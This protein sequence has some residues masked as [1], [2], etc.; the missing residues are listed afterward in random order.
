MKGGAPG[1]LAWVV[2]WALSSVALPSPVRSQSVVRAEVGASS[3]SEAYGARAEWY[4][5]RFDGWIGVLGFD[6][7][8]VG[9]QLHT[10]WRGLDAAV[11]DLWLSN[12]LPTDRFG[13]G[14][15]ALGRGLAVADSSGAFGWTV[16]G[17]WTAR[18]R[19]L[20]PGIVTA[21]GKKPMGLAELRWAPRPELEVG[22]RRTVTPEGES[23]L[24]FGSWSG[25]SVRMD[26]AVGSLQGEAYLSVAATLVTRSVEADVSWTHAPRA[27]RRVA[28]P[29]LSLPEL[30]GLNARVAWRPSEKWRVAAGRV[31]RRPSPFLPDTTPVR[32]IYDVSAGFPAGRGVSGNASFH[33]S[34]GSSGE[35]ASYGGHAGLSARPWPGIRGGL[36]LF[37]S[38]N[39][40]GRTSTL[41]TLSVYERIRPELEIL[42]RVQYDGSGA[43]SLSLGGQYVRGATRVGVDYRT[44]FVPSLEGP[45]FRTALVLDI[46]V[47]LTGTSDLSVST[48]LDSSGGASYRVRSGRWF[49]PEGTAGTASPWDAAA[50]YVFSDHMIRG[51][52]VLEDGTPVE[53]AALRIGEEWVYTD[54]RGRFTL[55]T[56]EER[57][58]PLEV[59]PSEFLLQRF[60]RVV[61]APEQVTSAP[62]SEASEI[63]IVVERIFGRRGGGS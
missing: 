53:G 10:R 36:S 29:E 15:S 3:A 48:Y 55:R 21:T 61:E 14:W 35:G 5:S 54:A 4:H 63:V 17:G 57:T 23:Q 51:R 24:H 49:Y 12:A 44:E 32:T 33:A 45:Q 18:A 41:S 30:T 26:G 8:T 59:V 25:G 2:A 46:R 13:G 47:A 56:D 19:S 62:E 1:G 9:G 16:F 52:V 39:P 11:G 60:Y 50:E 58:L 40:S 38:R 7:P 22:L 34:P 6:A 42:Q 37:V 27:G 43:P 20:V 31:Q 28:T